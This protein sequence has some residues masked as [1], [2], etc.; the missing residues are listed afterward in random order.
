MVEIQIRKHTDFMMK[1]SDGFTIAIPAKDEESTIGQLVGR[2]SETL[3]S[4]GAE[5]AEILVVDDRSS[6]NTANIARDAG[7]RVIHTTNV[8]STSSGS[9]G[10]GDAIWAAVHQCDTALIGFVDADLTDLQPDRIL[11]MFAPLSADSSLQLVKGALTRTHDG[12]ATGPGRVTALTARPLLA[13]LRPEVADIT[14][15]LS[16]LFATRT[17][18]IGS[19][20]LDCDYGVDV[21]VLLDIADGFG[22]DAILEVEVGNISHR[23]RSLD[24]LSA[25]AEQVARAIIARAHATT[26]PSDDLLRR[27]PPAR[28]A[29]RRAQ[30]LRLHP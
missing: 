20:W 29:R 23:R 15:P 25:T 3:R 6:D 13:L 26:I 12:V 1:L 18:T 21:G 14:D 4:T 5:H 27:R 17:E 28:A 11:S 8:C 7:A 19:L 22:A 30:S 16:G 9:A 24:Q 2:L 10:K